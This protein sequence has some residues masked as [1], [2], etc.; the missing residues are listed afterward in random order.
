[1]RTRDA[2][3]ADIDA[4]VRLINAAY[5]VERFIYDGDRTDAVEC[6]GL[7]GTGKLVLAER[8]GSLV[9]CIYLELRE[10]SGYF[11]FLSVLPAQ[12]HRG[13]GR[14]L[15]RLAEDWFRL[16][17]RGVS[18]LQIIDVR[19]ELAAFYRRLGYREAGT[20]PFPT[21]VATHLPCHF[22]KLA[23]LL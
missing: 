6:A 14:C 23:K 5:E 21:D 3:I 16:Q 11:G 20:M 19:G 18:E 8:D 9:G 22:V 10:R 12:Q 13:I 2:G 7:L 4:A 15:V 1:M 17:G